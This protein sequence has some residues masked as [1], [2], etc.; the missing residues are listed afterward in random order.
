[1]NI[2]VPQTNVKAA[3]DSFVSMRSL[4]R[5]RV[6]LAVLPCFLAD[7]DD[8]LIRVSDLMPEMEISVWVLTHPDVRKAAKVRAFSSFV[9]QRLRAQQPLFDGSNGLKVAAVR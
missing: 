3:V 6:G 8:D 9:G 7:Q 2:N 4:V 1:M 5:S